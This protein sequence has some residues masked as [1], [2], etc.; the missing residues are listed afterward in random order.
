MHCQ[1]NRFLAFHCRL[2]QTTAVGVMLQCTW[3]E[4]VNLSQKIVKY[5][6]VFKLNLF[7]R[8]FLDTTRCTTHLLNRFVDDDTYTMS[9]TEEMF[10]WC[11]CRAWWDS[12]CVALFWPCA[13][14]LQMLL[15]VVHKSSLM[16]QNPN[17]ALLA[18]TQLTQPKQK[19]ALTHP[20]PSHLFPLSLCF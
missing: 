19:K 13:R 20:P 9:C 7:K 16:C 12:L 5:V 14:E 17:G 2:V 15:L 6:F 4:L 11:L 8:T 3:D 10:V 1:F 18:T